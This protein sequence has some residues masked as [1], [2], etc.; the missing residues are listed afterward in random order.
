M[1]VVNQIVSLELARSTKTFRGVTE[2]CRSGYGEQAAMLNRSLFEGM[3]VAHWV[4][5]NPAKAAERFVDGRRF[6]AHLAVQTA[7]QMGWENEIDEELRAGAR[8][9]GENLCDMEKRFG[10]HGERLWTGHRNLFDLVMSDEHQWDES[11][12]KL[13]WEFL[14]IV[15]RDNN[16][17]L[18]STV[19]GLRRTLNRADA[20]GGQVWIGPSTVHVPL[21]LWTAHWIYA[22]TLT[23]ASERFEFPGDEELRQMIM[24]HQYNFVDLTPDQVKGAGRNGPCP[25]ESGRKYKLCHQDQVEARAAGMR[26][27]ADPRTHF[28]QRPPETNDSADI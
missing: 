2:L 9:E 14:K 3:A 27:H 26:A 5:C 25:C 23:L 12:R 24:R 11:R 13:L 6:D 18:H 8:L 17:L 16:Q 4:H 22:Q 1:A 15:H 28:V 10:R 19:E 21:A 7:E 20:H